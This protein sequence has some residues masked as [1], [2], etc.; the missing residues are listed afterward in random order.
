MGNEVQPHNRCLPLNLCLPLNPS[1]FVLVCPGILLYP[2]C[3]SWPSS[4]NL[5]NAH[6]VRWGKL[7][8]KFCSISSL[9]PILC[10]WSPKYPTTIS[11]CLTSQE[12]KELR[13]VRCQFRDVALI[14]LRELQEPYC[15]ITFQIIRPCPFCTWTVYNGELFLES[16]CCL[17][18]S[19]YSSFAA[20]M[21]P[22]LPTL[23]Q[24]LYSGAEIWAAGAV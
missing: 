22:T 19:I 14:Q 21:E 5:I 23:R 12:F 7:T 3:Q 13:P 20:S 4:R 10:C 15:N 8:W 9:S 6:C 16:I 1:F 18:L 17:F 24:L 11:E 2:P